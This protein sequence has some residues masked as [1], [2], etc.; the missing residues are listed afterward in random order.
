MIYIVLS[1]LHICL[2]H[3]SNAVNMALNAIRILQQSTVTID[4]LLWLQTR[5]ALANSISLLATPLSP[6]LSMA[7]ICQEGVQESQAMGAIEITALFLYLSGVYHYISLQP[8][9]INRVQRDVTESLQVLGTSI[10]LSVNGVLLKCKASLLLAE[11]TETDNDNNMMEIYQGIS[12]I[13]QE[14]VG[15]AL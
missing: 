5:A 7:T 2:Y 13:L 15:V 8:P 9:D 12:N 10:E 11:T 6:S 4:P 1:E 3:Y 14:Q